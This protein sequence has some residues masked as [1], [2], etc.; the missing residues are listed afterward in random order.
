[1][2]DSVDPDAQRRAAVAQATGHQMRDPLL[3]RRGCTHASA[4]GA[5]ASAADKRRLANERLEFLGDA[6]L[7]AA[8]C[9][10]LC[11]AWPEV[12]EGD[13]SRR[14]ARLASRAT[15]AVIMEETGLLAHCSVGLVAGNHWPESI[16]A[17]LMEGI[18]G[19][20]YLDGGFPA[21]RGAVERLFSSRIA[22]AAGAIDD[23]R[24]R[25]QVWALAHHRR[26]PTY[27]TSQ[28]GGSLHAPEF[29][30][31]V[32]VDD[33]QAAGVGGSRRKAEESAARA[34]LVLV[35]AGDASPSVQ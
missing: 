17:N 34:L 19:A 10:L 3:L 25:L 24:Q 8:L 13:L 31:V 27:T 2:A 30:A 22:D 9:D 15:L 12:D 7:G 4:C 28:T 21:L 1:M 23:D 11:T 35:G 16:K 32:V 14:K 29:T 6:V 26:L 20:I 33:R 5:Q 18:L